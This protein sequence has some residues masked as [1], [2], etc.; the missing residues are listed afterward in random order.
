MYVTVQSIAAVTE[1][2]RH[3]G[4]HAVVADHAMYPRVVDDASMELLTSR[5]N[6]AT[7]GC[8]RDFDT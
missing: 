6:N 5:H 1:P 3:I 8:V 2:R 7:P 4:A